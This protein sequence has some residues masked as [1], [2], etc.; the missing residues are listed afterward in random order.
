MKSTMMPAN[1]H[2]PAIV[3]VVLGEANIKAGAHHEYPL[4]WIG[5]VI[6]PPAGDPQKHEH[7]RLAFVR[8][9]K[10]FIGRDLSGKPE[11]KT[12]NHNCMY[13]PEYCLQEVQPEQLIVG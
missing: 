4:N 5:H 11:K 13:V 3:Q 7:E 12:D 6:P 10:P 2:R 8:F 1:L 9:P